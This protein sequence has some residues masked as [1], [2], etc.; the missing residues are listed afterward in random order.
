MVCDSRQEEVVSPQTSR[1]QTSWQQTS[2]QQ[3]AHLGLVVAELPTR[4][5]DAS[6]NPLIANL[7]VM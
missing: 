1:Q 6:T 2:W 7:M 3:M 5:D 4:L